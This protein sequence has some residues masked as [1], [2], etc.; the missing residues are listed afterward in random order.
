MSTVH[1]FDSFLGLPE[2]WRE[3]FPS[4]F[5]DRGGIPP[6]NETKHIQWEIGLFN[7]TVP[8]Y[9]EFLAASSTPIS[10]MHI[11]CDLYSSTSIIL[12]SLLRHSE[13]L[14][15]VDTCIVLLFNELVGYPSYQDHEIKALH[16]F[17]LQLI[18]KH[19]GTLHIVL[20][21]LPRPLYVS[22][23]TVGF[24]LCLF[25]RLESPLLQYNW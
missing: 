21:L 9:F 10:F 2:D 5:F 16:E 8:S 14:I 13:K 18:K 11:D 15:P 7:V 20:E 25:R 12:S 3:G 23:Q 19:H 1:G 6:Y 17:Y 4:G 22:F 24:R